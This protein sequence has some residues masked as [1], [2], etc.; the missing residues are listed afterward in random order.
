MKTL[1]K[2][3]LIST[4]LL[5]L[6][7]TVN[8][9]DWVYPS[10]ESDYPYA[11]SARNVVD[12]WNTYT[13]NCTSYAMWKINQAGLAFN[14]NPT[15]PNGQSTTL[16]NAGSWDEHASDI[17]YTVNNTPTVGNPVNWEAGSGGAGSAGHVAWVEQINADNSVFISEWNW[18]YADGNYN[19]RNNLSGDHYIQ[20]LS[21]CSSVISNKT[22]TSGQ[23]FNCTQISGGSITILPETKFQV[24]STV[25][26]H[27]N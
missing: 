13:R 4:I 25:N 19:E 12:Q 18:N 1:Y 16:G 7:S 8:A 23:T 20:L 6:P 21:S 27:I 26:L 11:T 15:G 2:L 9:T 24:G 3:I 17:G 22:V 10:N 5:L 14:N